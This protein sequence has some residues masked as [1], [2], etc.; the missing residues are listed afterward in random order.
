[1]CTKLKQHLILELDFTQ[2]Y[3]IGIDWEMY[4]KFFLRCEGK[5]IATSMKTNNL[6]KRTIASLEM[7]AVKQNKPD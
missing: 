1:M 5:K 6:E 3:R 2:R 7:P 4:G